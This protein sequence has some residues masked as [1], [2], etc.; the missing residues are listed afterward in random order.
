MHHCPASASNAYSTVL[1]G[2]YLMESLKCLPRCIRNKYVDFVSTRK[3]KHITANRTVSDG[4]VINKN[5]S[6]ENLELLLRKWF[7]DSDEQC[8]FYIGQIYFEKKR[9][10]EAWNCFQRS[11]E[12]FNDQRSKFQLGVMLY[13]NLVSKDVSNVSNPQT[14]ACKLFKEIMTLNTQV[15]SSVSD[16]NLVFSSAYNLGR[17]Y[18]KG[19]GV[20]LSMKD[21]LRCFLFAANN[22]DSEACVLAQTALGYLYSGPEIRDLQ[23]AFWWHSDACAN[24]S[25]ESQAALGVMYLYG[26]GVKV[27][28]DDALFC[29]SEASSRGS[30][31][32]KANLMYFYYQR[33]MFANV[34]YLASRMV[35]CDNIMTSSDCIQA[36]QYRAMSMACFLYA[37]CLKNGKGVQKDELLATELFSKSVEWDPSLAARYLNLVLAGEL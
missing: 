24:G 34:C 6:E 1:N 5:L 36:F 29:L 26:I 12:K 13:D 31:Y 20:C 19:Y 23:K 25:V 28:L 33:K 30:L 16:R 37:L 14:R 8:A 15:G 7:D 3:L 9:Y 18:Y 22:G 35:T 32:A 2:F 10:N 21:A 4:K 17:A 11:Y 27:N